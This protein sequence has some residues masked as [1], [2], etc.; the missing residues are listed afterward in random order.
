MTNK[1]YTYEDWWNGQVTLIYASTYSDKGEK[2][3]LVD[4]D[5][6]I[7]S[8]IPRIKEK[9]AELFHSSCENLLKQLKNQFETRYA[10]SQ[11]KADLYEGEW[12]QCEA[13]I[14]EP[15][16][17]TR[18]MHIPQWDT[19]FLTRDAEEIQ[20]Y[21]RHHFYKGILDDFSHVHSPNNPYQKIGTPTNQV[22]AHVIWHYYN[23]LVSMY[24]EEVDTVNKIKSYKDEL[25]FIVGVKFASGEID[26]LFETHKTKQSNPNFTE[27]A[28]QLGNKNL[29]PYLSESTNNT[30]ETDK[31]IFS[32]QGKVMKILDYCN[33]NNIEVVD[34]F[35][36]RVK[37][38]NPD[39]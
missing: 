3:T 18:E 24:S 27:I 16:P 10:N 38:R 6:F 19:T 13:I 37:K 9:Q 39:F 31:N 14:Y 15:L 35:H 26:K 4:W 21:I 7:E 11:M 17:F 25:W 22:L 29:R 34:S 5:K 1:K 2:I 33:M 36:K 23:W 28:R 20:N 12:K 8:D 30:N 32:N